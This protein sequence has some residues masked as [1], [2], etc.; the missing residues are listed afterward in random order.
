[1]IRHLVLFTL[2]ADMHNEL[3]NLLHDLRSLPDAIPSIRSLSCGPN[4][5]PT[6]FTAALTVDVDDEK[7]LE[8]YRDHPAHEPVLSRLRSAADQIQVAD[9]VI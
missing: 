8:A 2:R 1:M 6:P 9:I 5:A 7:A 3:D 4:L